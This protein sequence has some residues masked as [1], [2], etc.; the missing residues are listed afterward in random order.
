[1][2]DKC[3]T[4]V[5]LWRALPAAENLLLPSGQIVLQPADKGLKQ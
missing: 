5:W 3:I 1:M 4:K 2:K